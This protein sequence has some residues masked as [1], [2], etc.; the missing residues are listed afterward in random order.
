MIKKEISDKVLTIS[1]SRKENRGGI[2]TFVNTLSGY[3]EIFN[4]VA[5]TRSKNIVIM[6]WC[7]GICLFKLFW[8]ILVK[9][10]KIV[11]MHGSSY[12]SFLRKAIIINICYLLKV[13]SVYHMHGSE[14][15]LFYKKYNKRNVLKKNINKVDMLIALS[16]S[17][18][19]FFS[20]VTNEKKIHVV[21]NMV[22]KPEFVKD[23]S[24]YPSIIKFLFLGRIGCRKGIFDLLEVIKD[25]KAAL[26]NKFLLHAGG[27]GETDK[28]IEFVEK[29]GLKNLVKFE[30]WVSGEKKKVL[31]TAC[32]VYILPSYNEGLPIAILEAMSYGLPIISTDIGGISEA[33][34]DNENGFLIEPGNKQ[35]IWEC[36]SYYLT[37][38]QELEKMGRRS[39]AIV[40][41]FYPENII[42]KLNSIYEKLLL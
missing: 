25:N 21:N 23:Y 18:K 26:R 13:K 5:S 36:I 31:L 2:A 17:W 12:G 6:F 1:T 27:D 34:L 29:N 41:K 15:K 33:V 19:H 24:P 28:L 8:F 39:S 10:I 14:F 16:E 20:S 30:G 4:Y 7:F 9:R 40:T 32:D 11:H 22:D 37:H 35:Q 42:P 3:Y 38:P